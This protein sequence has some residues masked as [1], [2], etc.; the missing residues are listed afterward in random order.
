MAT[1]TFAL[2]PVE[3]ISSRDAE[4]R[5]GHLLSQLIYEKANGAFS[6]CGRLVINCTNSGEIHNALQKKAD[7]GVQGTYADALQYFMEIAWLFNLEIDK[8]VKSFVRFYEVLMGYAKAGST[9]R[10][11]LLNQLNELKDSQTDVQEK[12]GT[13]STSQ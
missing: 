7:S 8:M 9:R 4:Y 1:T 10:Q 5:A 12:N 11:Q 3:S 6:E 2:P 13:A